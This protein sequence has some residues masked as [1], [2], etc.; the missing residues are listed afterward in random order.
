MPTP[1]NRYDSA[2]NRRDAAASGARTYAGTACRAAGHDGERYTSTGACVACMA[3]RY[4]AL[5]GPPEKV[6]HGGEVVSGNSQLA[7][8]FIL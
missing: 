8:E 6:E 5:K 3:D 7:V 2:A 4:Q 1:L